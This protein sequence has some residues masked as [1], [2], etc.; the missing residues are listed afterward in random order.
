MASDLIKSKLELLPASPGCYLMKDINQEIIYVGKAIKLKNRVK[1]YFVGAHNY[2]TTKLVS[3]IVDFEYIVTATEK[4]ALLLEYNL[5]KKHA[6]KY[7][8]MFMD[9]KSYPYI[10]LTIEKVPTL[11]VVRN[12]IDKK[13]EYF[14]PFPDSSAAYQTIHLLNQLY[15]LRKCK[16]MP[17]KECLY[18]HIHQCLGPCINDI[19]ASVYQGMTHDIKRFLRGDVSDLLTNLKK[20]M[21]VASEKMDFEKAQE[22]L[23]LVRSIEH[24]TAKQQVQ[25][26]D[27]KDRDVFGFYIDKGYISIQG[28][29]LHNGKVLERALAIHPLVDEPESTFISFIMQYYGKNP[30][31]YEILLPKEINAELLEAALEVKVS[32]PLKGNKLKLVEMV[33]NNAKDSHKQKFEL[34]QK[35]E[36]KKEIAMS[37]LSTLFAKPIHRVEMFDN[38]HISGA[39]NVSGCVVFNDGEPSKKDYRLYRLGSYISDLDSMKEVIYRR[40][41]RILKEGTPMNDLLIVD[42]GWL[43]IQAAKEILDELGIDITIAGLVKDD[44]HRTS[45]LM[46]KKGNILNIK[47]DSPL[48]F[49]LTQMQDEVHRFAI[50]YH[51]KLRSKAMTK[52]VLDDIEGIGEVRKKE[53]WREFKTLKNLKEATVEELSKILPLTV[54]KNLYNALNATKD[55]QNNN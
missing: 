44:H 42:G 32:Q 11:K 43:Q 5:I 19:E 35:D 29:F 4:E 21:N 31:P 6:P 46:D 34:A 38:S 3:N 23:T 53:I 24:V 37:A 27:K 9:D 1:S 51:R 22:K 45:N 8:I 16:K 36:N 12:T 25:F 47:K 49:L 30:L 17:K 14:G 48:F 7:N 2:K 41:F 40:Y 33:I 52:S 20:E 13:A 55:G 54:S 10:K 15:P 39:F 28:F 26:N 50:T 18:Y